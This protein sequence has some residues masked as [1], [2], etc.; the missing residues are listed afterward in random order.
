MGIIVG[1]L[2]LDKSQNGLLLVVPLETDQDDVA[3]LPSP[4]ASCIVVEI[5][6]VVCKINVESK[7]TVER[8]PLKVLFLF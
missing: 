6:R 5:S 8:P 1:C 2:I 7:T 4:D 3:R